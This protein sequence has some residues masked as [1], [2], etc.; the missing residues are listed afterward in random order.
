MNG[1]FLYSTAAKYQPDS[2]AGRNSSCRLHAL[3][4]RITLLR[5]T[6]ATLEAIAQALFK[7]WFVDFDPVQ[8]KMEGRVP[9]GMDEATA[10]AVSRQFRGIGAGL[11]AEG[12]GGGF[13]IY[14]HNPDFMAHRSRLKQFNSNRDGAPLIR[15]RDLR[16]EAPGLFIRQRFTQKAT[17]FNLGIL[18]SAWMA[19]S[20]R[21]CVVVKAD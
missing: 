15:I 12:V 4:D 18:S 8:A 10:G 20:V 11:G 7:S 1:N 13:C 5:E 19:S 16:D 14:G 21:I 9:E 3:D 17:W 6:N 2:R